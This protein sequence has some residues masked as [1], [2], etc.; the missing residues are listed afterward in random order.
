MK[1]IKSKYSKY[2]VQNFLKF[3]YLNLSVHFERRRE[4]DESN[5]RLLLN[6]TKNKKGKKLFLKTKKY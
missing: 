6:L 2:K 4:F 5:Y 3:N 1:I